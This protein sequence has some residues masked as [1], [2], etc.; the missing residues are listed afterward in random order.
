MP[1]IPIFGHNSTI[2]WLIGLKLF[3][4]S[5]EI[6]VYRLMKRNYDFGRENG[7]GRHTG[8]KWSRALRPDQ[9]FGLLGGSFGSTNIILF[10]VLFFQ[11]K[12]KCYFCVFTYFFVFSKIKSR[13]KQ[14]RLTPKSIMK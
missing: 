13:P 7:R 1:I 10:F 9:K 6:I 3:M 12:K 11:I 14:K 4:V 2:F 5:H 8:A